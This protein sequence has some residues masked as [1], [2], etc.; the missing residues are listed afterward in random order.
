M[1]LDHMDKLYNSKNP[2][3]RYVHN[4]RLKKIKELVND[5]P[6]RILDCGCGEGHLLE[7]LSGTKY[8]VDFSVDSLK[9]ARERNPDANIYEANI[10]DLPFDDDFFAVT[11]CSE[12]LEHMPDYK[13]AINEMLRVTVDSGKIIITVPNE[14]NWTLGRLAVM[15]FPIKLEDHVNSFNYHDLAVAFGFEPKR[16]FYI[17]FNLTE[18]LALTQ[19]FE[20]DKQA[21]YKR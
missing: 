16:V 3:I 17:P 1:E 8:G 10:T 11:I 6:G 2:F 14:R 20:F 7:Q 5:N 12:V 15:H 9:R 18:Q 13:K 21:K 4:E 19:I